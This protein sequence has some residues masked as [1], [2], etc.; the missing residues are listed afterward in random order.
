VIDRTYP[1]CDVPTAIQQLEQRQ[2]TGKI[3]I[4]I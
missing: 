4:A 1:L 2:V 3:A